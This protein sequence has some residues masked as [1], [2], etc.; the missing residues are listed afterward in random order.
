MNDDLKMRE[1]LSALADGQLRGQEFGQAVDYASSNADGSETWQMYHLIGDVLRSSE[2]ARPVNSSLVDR[3]RSQIEAEGI[4]RPPLVASAVVQGAVAEV[5]T[6]AVAANAS[7]FRWKMAAGFASL[8]AVGAIGWTAM[9]G[10]QSGAEGAQMASAVPV[11]AA[12][13]AV[14]VADATEGSA[15]Q[16]MIRDPRLDELLAAHKQF[17]NTSALQMP[18]GF[19]R[20]ATFE[21]PAR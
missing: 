8:A 17:G 12:P 16:V 1:H 15:P 7:V 4:Q 3:L 18:A 13:A 6:P 19:L 5:V 10:I 14:A 2:L 11:T 20:N 21:A 9:T